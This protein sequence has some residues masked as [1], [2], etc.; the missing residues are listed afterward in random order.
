MGGGWTQIHTTL[1]NGLYTLTER[2]SSDRE[3]ELRHQES[4]SGFSCV[5]TTGT[6]PHLKGSIRT[7]VGAEPAT[8]STA[9]ESREARNLWVEL[10]ALKIPDWLSVLL[11]MLL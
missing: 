9:K 5:P 1:Q 3:E 4:G 2:R 10:A 11:S 8:A 6:R 7:P